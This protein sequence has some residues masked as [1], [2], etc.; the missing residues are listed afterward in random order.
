MVTKAEKAKPEL[1]DYA[2]EAWIR[3]MQKLF[4]L[5]VHHAD[6]TVTLSRYHVD[7]WKRQ[8]KTEYANLSDQGK[9]LRD[10]EA[11]RIIGVIDEVEE[12]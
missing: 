11:D 9:D 6:G 4:D 3:W 2:H 7:R 8:I 10:A 12:L 5:S 1:C